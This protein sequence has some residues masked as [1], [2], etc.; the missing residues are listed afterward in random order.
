MRREWLKAVL[1]H[2]IGKPERCSLC[3][4]KEAGG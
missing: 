1:W 2:L 3:H 4:A